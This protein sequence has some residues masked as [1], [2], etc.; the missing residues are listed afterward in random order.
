MDRLSRSKSHFTVKIHLLDSF[1]LLNLLPLLSNGRD[2]ITKRGSVLW[3]SAM[4]SPARCS[5]RRAQRST[6]LGQPAG[7][8]TPT[9]STP[10]PHRVGDG[11][12]R[13]AVGSG[14]AQPFA[15]QRLEEAAILPE[16]PALRLLRK[17]HSATKL[18]QPVQLGSPA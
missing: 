14:L 7:P 1:H 12:C 15:Q 3:G 4:P 11:Y 13:A 5:R 17:R 16:T 9:P 8:G 6:A 18:N 10:T 2:R